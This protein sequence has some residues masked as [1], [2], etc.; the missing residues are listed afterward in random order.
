MGTLLARAG[1]RFD[2]PARP[3]PCPAI[4]ERPKNP[5]DALLWPRVSNRPRCRV[6]FHARAPAL[7][8][9][10]AAR[11]RGASETAPH[12]VS[13]P[14]GRLRRAI[15]FFPARDPATRDPRRPDPS[16]HMFP[17]T[18]SRESTGP[19]RGAWYLDPALGGMPGG[20]GARGG[21]AAAAPVAPQQPKPDRLMLAEAC[22]CNSPA[23]GANTPE[24]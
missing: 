5:G 3:L 8:R 23:L 4:A 1:A 24:L 22:C 6:L 10:E 18:L 20:G 11:R 16:L 7:A 14:T 12:P 2:G 21:A 19:P 17:S 15:G 9:Y 13:A